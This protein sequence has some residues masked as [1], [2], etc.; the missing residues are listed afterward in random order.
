MQARSSVLLPY[1]STV[2]QARHNS[3]QYCRELVRKRDHNTYLALLLLPARERP[4]AFTAHAFNIEL[5]QIQEQTSEI[6]IAKGRLEF[7][8]KGLEDTYRG[9]P[10]KHPV[11]VSLALCLEQY[12]VS[13]KWFDRLISVR[14]QHMSDLPFMTLHD[15]EEYG[16]YCVSSLFY[17]QLENLDCA[18]LSEQHAASHLGKACSLATLMRSVPYFIQ[19]RKVFLPTE[20]C[21]HHA[22]SHE[23]IIRQ[24]NE[25]GV[26]E[27]IYDVASQAHV[28]LD[29]AKKALPDLSPRCQRIFLPFVSCDMFLEHLRQLNFD[30]YNSSFNVKQWTLPW[31]LWVASLKMKK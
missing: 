21:H 25:D 22:V 16:E 19:K 23:D 30:V 18:D 2:L 27:I 10:P 9:V 1:C 12:M 3:F 6:Q 4:I 20:L 26:R 14:K 28:H 5:A 29:H 31:K 11:L 15:A 7:W 24:K 17:I 8:R 13:E